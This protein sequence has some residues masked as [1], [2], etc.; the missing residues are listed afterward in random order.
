[1]PAR[2]VGPS[3]KRRPDRG[4]TSLRRADIERL[5]TEFMPIGDTPH[6][7]NMARKRWVEEKLIESGMSDKSRE[8]VLNDLPSY[9]QW[10]NADPMFRE[11]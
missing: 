9:R 7:R 4:R 1:M 11:V 6:R 3:N 5:L 10:E 8:L 2:K